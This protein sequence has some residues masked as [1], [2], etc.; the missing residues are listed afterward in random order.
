MS[1][2]TP[3]GG[4]VYRTSDINSLQRLRDLKTIRN[5]PFRY[6]H[7]WA[8][9]IMT[10]LTE[11]TFLRACYFI[12][13]NATLYSQLRFEAYTL[14]SSSS[15]LPPPSSIGSLLFFCFLLSFLYQ[16]R[17]SIF[18]QS[19]NSAPFCHCSYNCCLLHDRCLSRYLFSFDYIF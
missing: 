19:M 2:G 12:D 11:L 15:H 13:R 18:S 16:A 17:A 8:F 14:R 3:R 5:I 7:T 9:P 1:G 10:I 6:H 4:E